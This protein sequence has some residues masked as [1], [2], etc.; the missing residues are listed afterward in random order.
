MLTRFYQT[1]FGID[2]M[3]LVGFYN[4]HKHHP[5]MPRIFFTHDN[6][7]KSYTGN[8]DNKYDFYDKKVV[9]LVGDPRDVVVSSGTPRFETLIW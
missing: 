5:D 1:R 7:I 8:G 9:L 2:K 6:Y 4:F 3:E